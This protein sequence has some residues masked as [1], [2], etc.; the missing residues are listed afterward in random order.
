MKTHIKNSDVPIEEVAWGMTRQVMGYD[1][2]LML[3]RVCFK[4]DAV[5]SEHAHI[6]QQVTYIEKGIFEVNIGGKKE[7]LNDV[8][9]RNDHGNRFGTRKNGQHRNTEPC[10]KQGIPPGKR[11]QA[12]LRR[13]GARPL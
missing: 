1:T 12:A 3:V 6:H 10:H 9:G 13:Q 5:G 7:V 2:N 8:G 11:D 4:K